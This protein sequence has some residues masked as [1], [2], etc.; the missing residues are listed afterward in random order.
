MAE[1]EENWQSEFDIGAAQGHRTRRQR[2]EIESLAD[3]GQAD[4]RQLER[5]VVDSGGVYAR[6]KEKASGC[7]VQGAAF[8]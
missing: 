5:D 8:V 6:Q 4:N 1:K 7:R 3:T 2:C